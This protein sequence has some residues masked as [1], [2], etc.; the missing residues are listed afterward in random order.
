VPADTQHPMHLDRVCYELPELRV[1][2]AHGTDPWWPEAIRLMI[3]HSGL[4]L[5]TSAYRPKYLPQVLLDFM[6]TRGRSK[7]I[8]ATDWP[9]LG[10][11]T[12]LRDAVGL[13][14]P[15]DVLDGYLY[16]NAQRLFFGAAI[17]PAAPGAPDA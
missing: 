15:D 13:G 14:L 6:R 9:L 3:K 8:F 11:D 12:C 2:M 16:G 7:I 17:T 1:I 5:M 10:I 4:H